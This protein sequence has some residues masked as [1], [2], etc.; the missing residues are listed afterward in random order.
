MHGI[1]DRVEF[2]GV[3]QLNVFVVVFVQARILRYMGMG[4]YS[5]HFSFCSVIF[6]GMVNHFCDQIL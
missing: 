1:E 2:C 4:S 5:M 3:C 6:L